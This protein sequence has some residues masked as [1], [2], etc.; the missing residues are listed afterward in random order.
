MRTHDLHNK[1]SFGLP[2]DMFRCNMI[3]LFVVGRWRVEDP[4]LLIL[5][6]RH[7]VV[8]IF[9]E[10]AAEDLRI[11]SNE[12]A[13]DLIRQVQVVDFASVAAHEGATTLTVL[14]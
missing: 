7:K 9:G 4:D 1:A 11:K 5:A 8:A 13:L 10:A 12:L 14:D 3:D 2:G 6:P